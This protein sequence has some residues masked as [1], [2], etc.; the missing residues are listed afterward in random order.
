MLEKMYNKGDLLKKLL[1][2]LMTGLLVN[3]GIDA[4]AAELNIKNYAI[5][6][7][8]DIKDINTFQS[9]MS[10]LPDYYLNTYLNN[11]EIIR[12]VNGRVGTAA[13]ADT[14]FGVYWID[15]H[16]IDIRTD[17]NVQEEYGEQR[18]PIIARTFKHELGHYYYHKY[19]DKLSSK[20]KEQI[21][22]NFYYYKNYDRE[23]YDENETFAVLFSDYYSESNILADD[24]TLPYRELE[25]LIGEYNNV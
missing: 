25:Q 2:L 10:T 3:T 17:I 5:S 9:C 19:K 21:K 6:G 11:D 14:I 4:E 18:E 24:E 13:D 12:F 23:C 7:I 16:D 20:A 8:N 15:S 22:K 1:L